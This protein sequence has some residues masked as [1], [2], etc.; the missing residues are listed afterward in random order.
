[1]VEKEKLSEVD[2]FHL[3]LIFGL[4]VILFAGYFIYLVVKN[5]SSENNQ[6]GVVLKNQNLSYGANN[7]IT[8]EV[9]VDFCANFSGDLKES[10]IIKYNKCTTDECFYNQ[11]RLT[12]NESECFNIVNVN[13][14]IGCTSSINHDLIIQNAV[15]ENNVS[16][17]DKSE[18]KEV[19]LSCYDNFYYVKSVNTKDKSLCNNIVNVKVKDECLQ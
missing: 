4:V 12:R 15:L 13:K 17:C 5:D 19:V 16:L 3:Y 18:I 2:S 8:K 1:M 6:V 10:C 9:I 11:A 7:S 14:R